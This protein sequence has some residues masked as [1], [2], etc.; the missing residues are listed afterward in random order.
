MLLDFE[1]SYNIHQQFSGSLWDEKCEVHLFNKRD[2]EKKEIV[3][4]VL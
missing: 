1:W 3:L 4:S 2:E